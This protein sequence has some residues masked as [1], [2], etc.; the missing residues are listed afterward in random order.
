MR[1]S[2]LDQTTARAELLAA[3]TPHVPF[4]GWS[5]PAF[6]MAVADCGMDPDIARVI[7]PRGA[8]DLAAEYHR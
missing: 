1:N 4:D 8:A 3:I 7:C 2:R 5:E 6:R